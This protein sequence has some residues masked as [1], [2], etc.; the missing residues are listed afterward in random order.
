L[1]KI[2]QRFGVD[3]KTKLVSTSLALHFKLNAS[4][5]PR[6][7]DE[8]KYMAQ[9]LYANVVGALIYAMVYTRLDISYAVNMVSRYIHD[10]EKD[11]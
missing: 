5:S 7:E 6:I 4:M 3:G 8:C 2:L 10:S 1:K 11:H 9:I